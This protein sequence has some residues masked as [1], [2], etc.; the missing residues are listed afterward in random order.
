MEPRR[1]SSVYSDTF[2]LDDLLLRLTKQ[3]EEQQDMVIDVLR[4]E[5]MALYR[6]LRAMWQLREVIAGFAAKARRFNG[7]ICIYPARMLQPVSDMRMHNSTSLEKTE[8]AGDERSPGLVTMKDG[9]YFPPKHDNNEQFKNYAVSRYD[10][11][12]LENDKE[13]DWWWSLLAK[14]FSWLLLAGYIVFSSTFAPTL[15]DS[16]IGFLS[17]ILNIHTV[18]GGQ[19]S[20]TS[21]A[22]TSVT[23]VASRLM[24]VNA[25]EAKLPA[26]DC[27]QAE[28]PTHEHAQAESP[29]HEHA[30]AEPL[31]QK[32]ARAQK[33]MR[34]FLRKQRRTRGSLLEQ[35]LRVTCM[36][37]PMSESLPPG[38]VT[39]ASR[40]SV[41]CAA[42]VVFHIRPLSSFN[43]AVRKWAQRETL[44]VLLSATF[45]PATRDIHSLAEFMS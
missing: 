22:T 40:N 24:R 13:I 9:D 23:G 2:E 34:G 38:F 43:A 18:H 44:N 36:E 8:V 14:I 16:L 37:R 42:A 32:C 26:Q 5:A 25:A 33:G 15:A 31:A 21:I 19:W 39:T 7:L 11:M 1:T 10:Q 3:A 6:E 35:V 28:P 17:T 29:T 20:A 45:F 30:Q 27:A 12:V 41:H 4:Q